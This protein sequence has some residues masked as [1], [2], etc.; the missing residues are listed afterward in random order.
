MNDFGF[1]QVPVEEL[2][3]ACKMIGKD[4]MLITASD[5]DA[6][7]AMTASWGS[8]GV[9]WNKNVLTCFIRP[10][11][12]TY[13]LAEENER[14]SFAFLPEMYRNALRYCGNHSG[15]STH[16]IVDAGLS[17]CKIDGVPV[18]K[19]ADTVLICRKLYADD[20]KEEKFLDSSL[21]SNYENRDF[22]RMYVCEIEKVLKKK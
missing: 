22:H 16:K 9:L 10:Q 12:Y 19:E 8:L 21:L 5:G 17:T 11:R 4:W 14:M 18:I 2:D 1:Y 6:A 3:S 7:N 20:L 15:R 13:G